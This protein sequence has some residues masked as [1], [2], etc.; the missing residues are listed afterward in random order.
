MTFRL[1]LNF[2]IAPE[3]RSQRGSTPQTPSVW[4][5]MRWKVAGRDRATLYQTTLARVKHKTAPQ[6]EVAW[7]PIVLERRQSPAIL[8]KGS[9]YERDHPAATTCNPKLLVAS[10]A[11]ARL[12]WIFAPALKQSAR[13]RTDAMKGRTRLRAR[14][15]FFTRPQ[16]SG[17]RLWFSRTSQQR[18]R[19]SKHSRWL[20]GLYITLRLNTP[21]LCR[22]CPRQ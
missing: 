2:R 7:K 8:C 5:K 14:T 11:H 17:I 9:K 10:Y 12:L 19:H 18:H 4:P 22:H 3:R 15:L 13:L 21:G 20:R 16:V 1:Q 6:L